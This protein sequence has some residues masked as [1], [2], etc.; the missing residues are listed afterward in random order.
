MCVFQRPVFSSAPLNSFIFFFLPHWLARRCFHL[1][2]F[3]ECISCVKCYFLFVSSAF[4]VPDHLTCPGASPAHWRGHL[5]VPWWSAAPR[6]VFRSRVDSCWARH[7]GSERDRVGQRWWW[8]LTHSCFRPSSSKIWV[9]SCD[10]AEW[11]WRRQVVGRQTHLIS[12]HL[13][14]PGTAVITHL[15][16]TVVESTSLFFTTDQN[17]SYLLKERETFWP[18]NTWTRW[19]VFVKS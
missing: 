16:I 2:C 4:I 3:S 11:D 7:L 1:C 12:L 15:P 18:V 10:A 8:N 6:G 14:C 5:D 9:V 19:H 13:L 17:Q